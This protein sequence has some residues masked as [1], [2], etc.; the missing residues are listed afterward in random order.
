MEE[1]A[2]AQVLDEL[3]EL[4][5]ESRQYIKQKCSRGF[6]SDRTKVE[7]TILQI[8]AREIEMEKLYTISM[9]E[10]AECQCGA[11][12]PKV[13]IRLLEKSKQR[14]GSLIHWK[15]VETADPS[16]PLRFTFASRPIKA[17]GFCQSF[18][19]EQVFEESEI[20][21]YSARLPLSI[22]EPVEL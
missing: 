4:M 22:E 11:Q 13:F 12:H 3:D 5:A 16:I 10:Q 19:K 8:K 18:V 14:C 1:S 6:D 21:F 20:K 15:E 17:C 2:Q 7:L 9:W